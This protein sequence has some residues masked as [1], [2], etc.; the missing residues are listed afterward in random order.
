MK[1]QAK[2]LILYALSAIVTLLALGSFF[3][4]RLYEESLQSARDD[5]SSELQHVDFV[6]NTFFDELACDINALV[7][8][9]RVHATDDSTFTSFLDADEK[10]FTYHI[11]KSEQSIIDIFNN[12]RFSHPFVNSVYMGR[13]NGSFVR[14]HERVRPTR[15]DPRER[16]WYIIA[17]NNPGK[18]MKTDAYQ[19]VTTPDI[20]IGIVRALVDEKGVLYG[21]VGFD[22][23]LVQLTDYIKQFETSHSGRIILIDD[24][25][26]ILAGL[27]EEM[28]F[29][30]VR[31]YSSDLVQILTKQVQDVPSITIQDKGYYVF[32]V[33]STI[34]DWKIIA[35]IPADNIRRWILEQIGMTGLCFLIGLALLSIFTLIGLSAYVI[36]PLKR[37]TA[38][39]DYIAATSDLDRRVDIRSHDEIGMLAN[40]YN[41]MMD[42]LSRSEK[43]L[44]RSE[45]QYRDIFNNAVMGIYQSTPEGRWLNVNPTMASMFG[46]RTPEEMISGVKDIRSEL[47]V[48][49]EDRERFK[50]LFEE[51]GFVK[52]FEGEFK[53][54]DGSRFWISINGK[55]IRDEE[56]RIIYYEGTVED[57]TDRKKAEDELAAYHAHLEELVRER[58]EELAVA[59]EK[60]EAADHLKS[61]FLATM[62]HE[63][64]TPLN[65]IIGFTGIILQGLVGPLNDEQ[66]KQLNMVRNS[67]QHLL[68]LI[69]DVLDISKIEAGQLQVMRED[70]ELR[71]SIEKTVESARPMAGKKGLE[72]T[73]T[74]HSGIG[75]MTGDRRRVEQVLLNLISNAVKFTERGS[76]SVECE[77]LGDGSVEIRVIDTGIG[78][79]E[80][81]MDT[82]FQAFRQID[83]GLSRKHEGTG[84]GLSICKR[85]VE[86]MGGRIWVKSVWGS[87]STFGFS[88]PEGGSGR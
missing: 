26:V 10:T 86:L 44:R 88:L 15:Y 27:P 50:K 64:R 18:I 56:G 12:Y 19:S 36:R 84:L 78:I 23:T 11:G 5:M 70:Y 1:L 79:Q 16:P 59:K 48:D 61:A 38:D 72:L 74:I 39:T 3:Y 43:D 34:K 62:S 31:I 35:L 28:L 83:S 20:N 30:N 42:T 60:A 41:L 76:V 87:G 80:G 85:L 71:S 14:S 49:P 37:F 32:S 58:T 46:F 81:D 8:D 77:P 66:E 29:K 68:M 22:V 40:S 21:V 51:K 33:D 47:Y 67:A 2:L 45:K 55:A 53:R 69:N 9:E 63:L 73:C 4:P 25:G 82:I 54:R 13:E 7:A 6:L 57:I 24:K 75:T 52:S 65:S 17:K